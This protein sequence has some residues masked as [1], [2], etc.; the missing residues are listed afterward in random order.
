MP[1][2]N[3][4]RAADAE[5]LRDASVSLLYLDLSRWKDI[6]V[7][8]DKRVADFIRQT[9][10]VSATQKLSLNDGLAV[11]RRARA[12]RLVMGDVLKVG[13]R[14]I[15][16]ATVFD[17]RKGTRVRSSREET[18]VQ[19]S[20]IPLFGKLARG[21]LAVAPP[22]GARLGEIG[23]ASVS[24]F[25]EYLAGVQALNRFELSV[26]RRHLERA[27][28]IDTGFAL[29][30]YK[31]AVVGSYDDAGAGRRVAQVSV[32]DT[33]AVRRI[34]L[35]FL[36]GDGASISKIMDDPARLAH[37]TAATR[38]SDGLPARERALINGLL[39]Q[40]RG[41]FAHACDTYG[42][43]VRADSSD[44]EALYGLGKCL[45]Q[46]EQVEPIG[47]DT[48]QMRFR[49]SWNSAMRVL[50]SAVRLD[51]SSHLAF[52]DVVSILT[53][54]SRIGCRRVEPA[55][56]CNYDGRTGFRAVVRRSGDS[57]LIVPVRDESPALSRQLADA[58]QTRSRVRGLEDARR[59]A[60]EWVSAAPREWRAHKTLSHVLLR[61]GR[62]EAAD[63]ELAEAMTDTAWRDDPSVA[64][65][66]LNLSLKRHRNREFPLLIDSLAAEWTTGF[67]RAAIG[68]WGTLTG[69]MRAYDDLGGQMLRALQLP[70]L[71]V[72]F[73]LQATRL[74]LGVATDSA[75]T[76]EAQVL[77]TM[78][79]GPC[80]A[81]C[82]TMILPNLKF[83]LRL[84]RARWPTLDSASAFARAPA[85]LALSRRDTAALRTVARRLDSLSRNA[86]LSGVPE[87]G[88]SAVAADAMLLA[89]DS[90]GALNAV[91][92]MLDSTLV[93]TPFELLLPSGGLQVTGMLWPRGMLQR[94]QLAAALHYPDEARLWYGR[95]VELW[96]YADPALQPIVE[97]A[98]QA[99]RS[100]GGR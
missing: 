95:F 49:S 59:A 63:A 51:P 64:Y 11:A 45:L 9:P 93:T 71:L 5:W 62:L 29:A 50:R 38:S 2:D 7:V 13:S 80:N 46:D 18:S 48:T 33:L 75:L 47:G 69:R 83:G 68:V 79:P 10:G 97:R 40:T 20:L 8:D 36:A 61:L 78:F 42:A 39:A 34:M 57:L 12:G 52:D 25:Q 19:D 54:P 73:G 87:D 98:R 14:T 16:T 3:A 21:I 84:P 4:S 88:T 6:H 23:T 86:A 89:G 56:P 53:A 81:L 27:L 91:R 22:A 92:R 15:V 30:H 66:R 99:Y 65:L 55:T 100:L 24:A 60:E 67:P 28:Q 35:N 74:T 94:A 17:V 76:V 58:E 77:T 32:S 72:T 85:A 70:P 44:V 90:L 43:L 37:A 26:A 41:D 1:F 31:L 82:V 96:R